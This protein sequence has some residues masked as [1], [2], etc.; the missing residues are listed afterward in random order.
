MR[1]HSD[2]F[3]GALVSQTTKFVG[4]FERFYDNL[5][6]MIVPQIAINIFACALLWTKAPVVSMILFALITTYSLGAY[7][8]FSKTSR[9]NEIWAKTRS[10]QSG[11]LADSVSNVL[12]VKSHGRENYEKK[13]FATVSRS[14]FNSGMNTMSVFIGRNIALS[15]VSVLINGVLLVSVIVGGIK[16]ELSVGTMLLIISYGQQIIDNLWNVNNILRE[17]NRNFGDAYEMVKILDTPNNVVDKPHARAIAPADG[18]KRL[19]GEINFNNIT[20]QHNGARRAIFKGF[21]LHIRSGERV[22]LVGVSGSGKTTLTKLLLRFADVSSGMILIDGQNISDV[23][24]NSLRENIAYVPQESELFHRTL[25][26]NI[27]Y[28]K[29]NASEKEIITAAKLAN[30][31]EFIENLPHGLDTLTGERGVK[32]SGGQRQRVI[33]A[34]A[35][36]KNAPILVLDEATSA[37]DSESEKL[38]Q[39]ALRTLMHDRTSLVIAHRLSTVCELDRIVV[40]KEGKIVEEGS[41][42]ELIIRRGEYHKLWSRQTGKIIE[43]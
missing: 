7:F 13:L 26:Q 15:T 33:I 18:G 1:F 39:D 31:W 22:G 14:V 30:A 43:D 34:R 4:A 29:P 28:G 9:L 37:L 16:F 41:H 2:K 20:F 24:Q 32:L 8:F 40:L 25:R 38:I 5:I 12:S 6:F 19:L 21:N 27:G 35:I 36:L 42:N 3:S 10:R 17:L 11:R 23:T